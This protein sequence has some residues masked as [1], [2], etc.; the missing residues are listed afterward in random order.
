MSSLVH[1]LYNNIMEEGVD[2]VE[3]N[4]GLMTQRVFLCVYYILLPSTAKVHNMMCIRITHAHFSLGL[5]T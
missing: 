2:R 3:Q 1:S 5:T 4:M